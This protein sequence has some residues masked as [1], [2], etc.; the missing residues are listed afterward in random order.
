MFSRS[1]LRSSSSFL[2]RSAVASRGAVTRSFSSVYPEIKD[3]DYNEYKYER[4]PDEGVNE[5]GRYFG[6][7]GT[8]LFTAGFA[9]VIN[10]ATQR[11][12]APE[13]LWSAAK[14]PPEGLPGTSFERTFIAIKPDGVQRGIIGKII[15]RFEE[16]GFTLVAMK[17][18]TPTADL[19]TGHYSDLSN[20]P[21]FPGLVRFFSSGPIIAMVW[22]GKNAVK[23]G[24]VMLGET[25]P[26]KSLPGS[27]RGDYSID[28]GRN[29]IHG[30]DSTDSAKHE[31][32]FWF[33]PGEVFDWPSA[34]KG[35]VYEKPSA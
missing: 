8:L 18:I 25:D 15:A 33:A 16:K 24:R 20:K 11:K 14:L 28:V 21:F 30:S 31:I 22:E 12:E 19:A 6:I 26:A 4:K 23:T 3:S 27:I 7:S 35:W 13:A 9:W 2:R 29:I 5:A 10:T 17:L 32:N 34:S 1:L